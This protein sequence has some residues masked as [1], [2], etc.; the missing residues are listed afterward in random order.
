MIVIAGGTGR[1]GRLAAERL[2][3]EGLAVRVLGRHATSETG[4]PYQAVKA[5]VRDPRSLAAGCDGAKVIV[6]AMHGFTG[7]GG[8]SPASV[9]RDGNVNLIDVA[10]QIGADVVL[11]SISGA[12]ADSPMELF[13]MKH[14]AERYLLASGLPA[15]IVRPTA[16]VELW[17]DILRR[18]AARS[19]RPV[20][21]GR[22]LNP[23]NFVSVTDVAALVARVVA[24][25]ASR[26]RDFDI[27]GPEALTFNDLA[28]AVQAADGRVA[29]PRHVPVAALRIGA[30][31]LGRLRPALG[32]QL[33][34]AI[35]MDQL[36]LAHPSQSG[37][38]AYPD[39]PLTYLGDLVGRS[40]RRPK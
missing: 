36:D 12:A 1:L 22:G 16:F 15:T 24:D 13:R 17:L 34:A 20:V 32:R 19:G 35:A 8:N 2:A 26:G 9:D 3:G 30:N 38:D 29:P 39:V 40:D 23:I 18:T 6:S 28:T 4:S 10:G 14:A 31:S 33:R 21:F 11:T 37:R 25:P 27:G 5:D 7:A